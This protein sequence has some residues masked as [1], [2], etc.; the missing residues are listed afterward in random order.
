[1][2][3]NQCGC[4]LFSCQCPSGPSNVLIEGDA[5]RPEPGKVTWTPTETGCLIGA[6]TPLDMPNEPIVVDR[7]E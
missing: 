5:C 7:P 3:C 4:S 1:M 2:R 6:L